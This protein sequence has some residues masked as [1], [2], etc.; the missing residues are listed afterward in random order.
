MIDAA[1]LARLAAKYPHL[2]VAQAVEVEP[3]ESRETIRVLEAGQF[4]DRE[5]SYSR[6]RKFTLPRSPTLTLLEEER[7]FCKACHQEVR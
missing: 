6:T 4:V 5:R 2:D 1:T 3:V 7:V